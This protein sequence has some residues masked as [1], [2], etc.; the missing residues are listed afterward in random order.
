VTGIASPPAGALI[1]LDTWEGTG[2]LDVPALAQAGVT[3]IIA[4]ASDGLRTPPDPQWG[5]TSTG[6]LA[7]AQMVL[8]AYGV[9]ESA[10]D[11]AAQARRFVDVIRDVYGTAGTCLLDPSC[12]F[13][14]AAHETGA[15]AL[16]SAR[17][18]TDTVSDALGRACMLYTGPA[19]WEYLVKLAKNVPGAAEDIAA[20][21]LLKLWLADYTGSFSRAPAIPLPWSKPHLWQASGGR[22]A[23]RNYSTL[24]GTNTDVDVDL[25]FGTRDDLLS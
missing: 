10:E 21:G 2:R 20:L 18:Y 24:P 15:Q 3:G 19:F 1:L 14:V 8:G 12:D 11:P 22:K 5:N 17:V 7:Q 23:S 25:F 13:E 9:I 6:V 16:H 4:K